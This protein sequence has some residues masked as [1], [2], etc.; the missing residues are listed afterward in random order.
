MELN[1]R[2]LR[3]FYT[4]AAALIIWV[5]AIQDTHSASVP[6]NA[7]PASVRTIKAIFTGKTW[8]WDGSGGYFRKD[9]KFFA[10]AGSKADPIYAKG[11]W[12][13]YR[14]GKLCFSSKWYGGDFSGYGYYP[15]AAGDVSCFEHKQAGGD[16][17]QR[18]VGLRSSKW[19]LFKH[20]KARKS[21]EFLKVKRGDRVATKYN[22][23]KQLLIAKD[24][25]PK[26]RLKWKHKRIKQE[27]I[28]KVKV[29]RKRVVVTKHKKIRQNK[30]W[31][32]HSKRTKRNRI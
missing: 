15:Y 23:Y 20:A 7:K 6:A 3:A 12:A 32:W 30:R 29:R 5:S 25:G 28:V 26:T 2:I 11:A 17:Y 4:I 1:M 31:R 8:D 27:R 10:H 24:P 16:I 13:V 14:G 22:E 19:Y 18:R 21:D 9:G